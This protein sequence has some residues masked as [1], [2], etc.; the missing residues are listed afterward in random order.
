MTTKKTYSDVRLVGAPPMSIGKFGADTD[1]YTWPRHSADFALFRIYADKDGNPVEY[2]EDNVPLKPKR[3][4][5]IS[6][7]GVEADDFAMVMGF[8]GST[9]KYFTSWEVEE[10][11]DIDNTARI[12]M[13][14]IRQEAMMEE[15]LKDVGVNI[16]YA[17][18]YRS[19]SNAYKNAIGTNWAID[20]RDFTQQK[21]EQQDRLIS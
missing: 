11:R 6:T 3:W 5:K 2:S 14:S 13:R 4:F 8:P 20:L 12:D 10:R 7:A 21:K 17:S 19:S 15:M 18:K 1:N 9:Y 16:Q